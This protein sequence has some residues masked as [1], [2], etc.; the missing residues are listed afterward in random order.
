[1]EVRPS[2]LSDEN[3]LVTTSEPQV[4]R[5]LSKNQRLSPLDQVVTW[6]KW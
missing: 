4:R 6:I 5:S 2:P 3:P 1:M